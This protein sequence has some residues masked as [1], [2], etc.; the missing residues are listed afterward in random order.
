MS[1]A[2]KYHRRSI[3]LKGYDYTQLQP[4]SASSRDPWAAKL[5]RMRRFTPSSKEALQP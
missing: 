5:G 3:R 2:Y 1:R 4:H